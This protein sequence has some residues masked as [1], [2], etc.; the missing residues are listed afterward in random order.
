MNEGMSAHVVNVLPSVRVPATGVGA[1]LPQR[2]VG[3]IWRSCAAHADKG[4]NSLTID[5]ELRADVDPNLMTRKTPETTALPSR[6]FL[7]AGHDVILPDTPSGITGDTTG[8]WM[9]VAI[10]GIGERAV[11]VVQPWPI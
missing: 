8:G 4:R 9:A 11:R 7:P 1:S 6:H 2:R 5:G 10:G 3:C